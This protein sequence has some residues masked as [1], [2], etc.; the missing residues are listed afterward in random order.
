MISGIVVSG[1]GEVVGG[2]GGGVGGAADVGGDVTGVVGGVL[3]AVAGVGT[4]VGVVIIVGVDDVTDVT[5]VG[6]VASRGTSL[7]GRITTVCCKVPCDSYNVRLYGL[8]CKMNTIVFTFRYIF[9]FYNYF[10]TKKNK[11]ILL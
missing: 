2:G 11:Q 9:N 4:V 5:L 7:D 3:L 8:Y 10:D 1:G 6:G